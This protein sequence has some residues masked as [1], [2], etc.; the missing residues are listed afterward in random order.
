MPKWDDNINNKNEWTRYN[1]NLSVYDIN[2]IVNNELY[3]YNRIADGSGTVITLGGVKKAGM[4]V[5]STPIKGNN[6]NLITSGGVA[7]ALENVSGGEKVNVVDNLNSSSTT[8]ALSANQ[9]KILNTSKLEPSN[10]KAGSNITVSVDGNDVTISGTGGSE[11]S[12]LPVGAIFASAIPVTDA[13]VHLLNGETIATNGVYADF[14]AYLKTQIAAGYN[15]TC[16]EEEF[17]TD[18]ANTGNCGK[19]VL[20][21][22][23]NTLRLPK[24][25][26]FIQG[27][28]NIANLGV[29]LKAGLPNITGSMKLSWGD[30]S[31]GGI[32]LGQ[33]GAGAFYK[34][35]VGTSFFTG[36]GGTGSQ[37]NTLN[38]DASKSSSVYGN[39]TTVQPPATMF[40]YYI[41]LA[42]QTKTDIQVDIDNIVTDLNGKAS[43]DEIYPVGSIYTSINNTSP[44]SF[45]GGEWEA[46]P[47]GRTLWT[48]TTD[49][50]GGTLISAGLPN[51]TGQALTVSGADTTASGAMSKSGAQDKGP[52]GTGTGWRQSYI[53]FNASSSNTIYGN[54]S[55]VQP[56]AIRVYMWKR[57]S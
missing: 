19:F 10:I 30:A 16:T 2:K 4:I 3:L 17:N 23:N 27:L 31:G 26:K 24:I 29:S 20:D 22:T 42:T 46:L 39:S 57:V 41:V 54:S 53:Y 36:A 5:D 7:A 44:A 38:M 6:E 32:I 40:P 51:I 37:S 1:A 13:G 9:G 56:P 15:L 21:E 47:E 12:G 33:D 25:T 50:Q 28:D 49:G 55:T 8:D 11:G 43:K 34:S 35:T 18:V 14:V 52:T 48:T 45:F